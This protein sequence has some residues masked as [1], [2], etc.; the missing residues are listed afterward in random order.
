[1]D[2]AFNEGKR[3]GYRCDQ[4]TTT[5]PIAGTVNNTEE[6]ANYFDGITYSKGAAVLKQLMFLIGEKSFSQALGKYF[7][8]YEWSNATLDD[9]IEIMNDEYKKKELLLDLLEWKQEW[10]CTAG[11]NEMEALWDPK[12]HSKTQIIINQTN[13]LP[14][15][16]K[17]R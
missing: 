2:I 10:I 5:H 7:L 4:M 13:C 1:M 14:Q 17:E 16:K 8:K 15:F 11:L 12:D 3:G 6:I 9:F